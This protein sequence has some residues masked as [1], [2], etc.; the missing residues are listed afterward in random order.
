MVHAVGAGAGVTTS[1]QLFAGPWMSIGF[2][3][4]FG[5]KKMKNTLDPKALHQ[6][7]VILTA[8]LTSL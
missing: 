4:Q 3:K 7:G 8:T 5:E 1:G 2:L 6:A